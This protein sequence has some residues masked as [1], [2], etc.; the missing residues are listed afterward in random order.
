[1]NFIFS[2]TRREI[3]SSWRRL[4][5]FF[6]CIALGVGS[7]VALRSLIQNLTR[8]VGTDARALLTADIELNS[9][10]DFSPTEISKIEEVISRLD[11]VEDRNESITTSAMASPADPANPNTR[12]VELKG[13]EPPFPLV[14]EFLMED[15]APFDFRLLK[16]HGAVVAKILLEDL[17]VGVGDRIRIGE[18]EFQIRGIFEQEPGGSSGFRLGARV[19]VE[20]SA[21]D[22]AGITRNSSRVRRVILYR[23]S[24]NPTELVRQLREALQG[25]TVR[26]R[27]YRETQENIGEQFT[28][29]ENYLALTGLLI[30]VLGGVGVW[31][32]ARAFVEQKRKSVAVLKC[33]GA[34][35]TRI[36]SVYL[37]QILTLGLVGS[38]FGVFL[39]Q[40]GLLFVRWRFIE[41]LP[42]KMS[43]AV[44]GWTAM[45]GVLLGVAISIIFSALPLLQVRN[46]KP[47]LLL[48]DENNASL[49]R[50]DPAKWLLGLVSVL[51][52]LGLAVW[53]AGSM[54]VGVFFLVGLAATAGVLYLAA[55]LLTSILKRL[56]IFA[57]F[58]LRQ[59]VN[60]LHR[61]GN[62]TRIILLAVGLGAFVVLAVHSLQ[63]NLVREFDFTLNQR[64]PSLFFI[65]IQKSQIDELVRIIEARIGEKAETT[66][67]VRAR[68]S[69]I[70]GEA[71]DFQQ[72]EVR[73]Q[74][75]QIGREFSVTYRPKLDLNETVVAGKWWETDSDVP[76][77]SVED[78][79][80][81]RL[82]VDVGDSI[83]FDISGRKVTAQVANLRKI[84]LRNTRTAFIFVFRPGVLENAPQSFAATVLNRVPPT[85]RQRLQRELLNIFPNIQ[86]FDVADIVATVQRLVNNFVL[87]IS[88]VGS[89]VI[90][91]GI[92]IL[93]GSIALT[94]SQRIY[95]NAILKTLG[96]RRS[97]LA[98]ILLAEYGLLGFLAGVIGAGFAV[99]LSWSVSRFIMNI[100]WEFDPAITI[101]GIAATS[102][103]VVLVGCLASFDVLFRKPLGT[104]RSQ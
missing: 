13:I 53:Q 86:I 65:D 34:G 20:K 99:L 46:I 69:H 5:F 70:N 42:E 55:L 23:T 84:D 93:I 10:A 103:I 6:L 35:G 102:L 51:A 37:L 87:A 50:L 21:F 54:I 16:D 59:A 83:T 90:L 80:A 91:S 72:R 19:F 64:L 100:R 2:L 76:Q 66:P 96:A 89:F 82:K 58:S 48:R 47:R 98:A 78:E 73:E 25:T 22:T 60:S 43:Y 8:A 7:I 79:M 74:R 11:I 85:E 67:T 77:V 57:S 3:R 32:V 92:L 95:E 12:L 4:L 44:G 40:S 15:G 45:Q 31:N 29:T 52:L 26:V 62:Q 49:R 1:M 71:I 27:S 18:A 81:T 63:A 28:R 75:G 30:L 94:K 24:E 68:I 38:I 39:A 14:G 104:L 56:K 61:P 33:L 41:A 36:I 9:T 88:F 17:K 101:G 97:T